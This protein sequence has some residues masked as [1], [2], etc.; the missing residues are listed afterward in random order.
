MMTFDLNPAVNAHLLGMRRRA[1]AGKPYVVQLPRGEAA[2]WTPQAVAYWQHF[3]DL[4]GSAVAPVSAPKSL[5]VRAVAVS[6]KVA[7]II[8]PV[9]LNIV[10]QNMEG[11]AFD[12]VIATNILVY[13]ER[14]E[15]ALAMQNIARMMNPGGV[16]LSNTV[17]P[18]QKPGALEYLGRRS[19]SYSV[20]GGYGDDIVAYR[21]K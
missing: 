15:Q 18:A 5:R 6:P 12:L 1:R 2:D 16:F 9:D 10:A 20:S 17:L 4:I 3:G 8:E 14:F 21:R 11:G 13:Y 19:I 7:A